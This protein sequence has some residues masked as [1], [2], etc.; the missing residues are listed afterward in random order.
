ML[1]YIFPMALAVLANILYHIC[2]KA[3]VKDVNPMISLIATYFVALI[4]SLILMPFF[5]IDTSHYIVQFKKLNW[6]SY[7]LAF[8]IIGLELGFLL[9]YRAGWLVSK[10]ALYATVLVSITLIPIGILFYK[11]KLSFINSI[12]IVL[13]LGGFIMMSIKPSTT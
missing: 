9:V 13:A 11:E 6:A 4:I 5:N 2:Q 1:K 8:G 10:A 7:A 3:I 12:G